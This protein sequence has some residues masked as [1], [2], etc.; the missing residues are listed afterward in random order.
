MNVKTVFFAC[1]VVISMGLGAV[2]APVDGCHFIVGTTYSYVHGTDSSADFLIYKVDAAGN[3]L[4]RKNLGGE[5]S[6]YLWS[7]SYTPTADGGVVV[8]GKGN[9]YT[10]GVDDVLV[11]RLDATGAKL[12][13]KNYGGIG[14]DEPNAVLQTDD[15]G[16]LVV[17]FSDS[18]TVGDRDFLLVKVDAAGAKQWRRTFGGGDDDYAFSVCH[19]QDGGYVVAGYT[20]SYIHLP[21]PTVPDSGRGIAPPD[22]L[23]Y[24]L[25]ATG[26]KLWRKNLGGN[27]TDEAY[28]VIDA[29]DG[30]F[31]VLGQ[32]YSYTH[33]YQDFLVYRLDAAGNKQWRRNYGGANYDS[34]RSVAR[35]L[36]GGFILAGRSSTYTNGCY[37]FLLYKVAADGAKLWRKNLGGD[38]TDEAFTAYAT[39]DEGYFVMGTTYSYHHGSDDSDLLAYKLDAAGNK[40]WRKNYG[41]E[42]D[43]YGWD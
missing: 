39:L 7:T 26:A 6:D 18:Y 9:S 1:L 24:R 10:H 43:E 16:F 4:W 14:F 29:P 22:F 15:G 8:A 37:D 23:V 28:G 31:I 21:S 19:T 25:D 32:T 11:Y 17:G 35:T 20:H 13:R 3:K 42:H 33:G 36:D 30:G 5:D 12:W 34:G 41:G 2:E 27:L 38:D 40:L